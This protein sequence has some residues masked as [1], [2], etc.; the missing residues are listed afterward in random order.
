MRYILSRRQLTDMIK[1]Q[2]GR[3]NMQHPG[4]GMDAAG[5]FQRADH[6]YYRAKHPDRYTVLW[7]W[8]EPEVQ[9]EPGFIAELRKK[10]K[11]K[12]APKKDPKKPESDSCIPLDR[13]EIERY[14]DGTC[15]LFDEWR[16]DGSTKPAGDPSR[17]FYLLARAAEMP[18]SDMMQ[19]F[20]EGDGLDVLRYDSYCAYDVFEYYFMKSGLTNKELSEKIDRAGF[21]T[22][23]IAKLLNRS[24]SITYNQ[25]AVLAE[26]LGIPDRWAKFCLYRLTQ[27]KDRLPYKLGYQSWENDFMGN[28]DGA[29]TSLHS[30]EDI[31]RSKKYGTVSRLYRQMG[32]TLLSDT[33][34]G[35]A[36][37]GDRDAMGRIC[38]EITMP[39]RSRHELTLEEYETVI[40]KVLAFASSCMENKLG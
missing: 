10:Y 34:P 9:E 39:D 33:F 32:C 24:D 25:F 11:R 2:L 15:L 23:T 3:Y 27:K 26:A 21:G 19:A 4:E 30:W 1:E 17:Q 5:L 22:S 37:I 8:L 12:T 40:K 13:E 7:K 20:Y 6:F 14:M 18:E 29:V 36:D 38:M 16:E 31:G 35:Q 28:P